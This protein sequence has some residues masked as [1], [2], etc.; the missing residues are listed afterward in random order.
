M[1]VTLVVFQ[2]EMS[3]LKAAARLNISTML[4]TLAVFQAEML[5]LN[6]TA[7]ENIETM[8]VTLAVFQAAMFWLNA[9]ALENIETML[10][11]LVVFQAAM[12]WLND[13]VLANIA[14][15][16]VTLA[17]FQAE[18]FGLA[19]IATYSFTPNP[20]LNKLDM[21][22]TALT[23]QSAIETFAAPCVHV[24]K[25]PPQGLRAD[26]RSVLFVKTPSAAF[27]RSAPSASAHA[28]IATSAQIACDPPWRRARPSYV[29]PASRGAPDARDTLFIF[30][31]S[32]LA[33]T[34]ARLCRVVD[35]RDAQERA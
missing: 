22:S 2:A 24:V 31:V 6:A 26:V 27:A 33:R 25:S 3:W 7:L 5:W 23:S 19:N 12:F 32:P 8:F 29:A 34:R 10:V 1:L 11:T 21:S 15:M 9:A 14:S 4:V 28:T 16:F 13:K 17:V 35:A 30:F 20:P 18:M